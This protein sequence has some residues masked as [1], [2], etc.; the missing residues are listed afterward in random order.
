MSVSWAGQLVGEMH[1]AGI[2][3]RQLAKHMGLTPGYVSMILNGK[4]SP[5]QV[6]ERFRAAVD[7][8]RQEK[9]AE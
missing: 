3:G 8:I 6:E 4:K 9:E 5:K 2:T 1:D 7:E